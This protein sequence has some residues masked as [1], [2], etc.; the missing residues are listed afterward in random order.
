M[1]APAED[2]VEAAEEAVQE[3][4]GILFLALNRLGISLG[5]RLGSVRI[6]G[7]QGGECPNAQGWGHTRSGNGK[8]TWRINPGGIISRDLEGET[9][10]RP[11]AS[12]EYAPTA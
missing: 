6:I 3:A 11:T 1:E 10:D 2:Q 7:D 4:Q 9:N 12:M 5:L 8:S